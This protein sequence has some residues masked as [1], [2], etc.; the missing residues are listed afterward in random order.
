[1]DRET[2]AARKVPSVPG[3]HNRK[4]ACSLPLP[5][6]EHILYEENTVWRPSIVLDRDAEVARRNWFYSWYCEGNE[7]SVN[8][9]A[10]KRSN[11]M[12]VD[13]WNESIPNGV[14]PKK[15]NKKRR[16]I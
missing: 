1:M 7:T 12:E 3:N 15:T 16:K 11:R 5:A 9:L 8:R 4:T 14:R 2:S 13:D 6:N 10:A